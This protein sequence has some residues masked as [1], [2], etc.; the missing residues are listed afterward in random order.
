MKHVSFM[1]IAGA[2]LAMSGD[3]LVAAPS[4]WPQWQGA[5]RDNLSTETGLLKKWPA[6]GPPLAWKAHGIGGGF[7]TVSVADGK[8]F[9]MGDAADACYV[10]ALDLGGNGIWQAKVGPTG[11]GG[12]Y[13]GP[14]CAP[15]V[16]GNTVVA[17]GQFGDL[18]CLDASTGA[19]KWHKNLQKDFHGSMMSGWGYAES[20]L[21]D[22]D[23]VICT[24][25][26]SDGTLLALD[27]GTGKQVWRCT[28]WKDPAAYAS[29]VI[30]EIGGVR[31]YVQLT[32]DSVGGVTASDGKLLWR[33]DRKGKTA[34]IP[35]PIV[36]GDEIFVTSGYQVGCNLF[37]IAADNG[38]FS[39]T[40]V[41]A[42][43]SMQNHHGGV[44]LVGD[45]L[46]GSSD[47]GILTCMDFQTGK[48]K[49]KDRSVGKGSLTYADGHLYLRAEGSG[50]V[51]LVE[52]T[53]DGYHEISILHQP[54]RSDAKAWPHPVI[55]DGKLYLRD[56]DLLLCYD[57]K[58]H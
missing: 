45:G 8:I 26:G 5:R 28:Q 58:A 24:P 43:K 33:A 1:L 55:A 17:L 9:T 22:Q 15:T 50:D 31:Q 36:K 51:A 18:V 6:D 2:L 46:Y 44:V 25:G 41:Y 11:G 21:I 39:T 34:V 13:P 16:S 20:P 14:R 3:K 52:A 29:P 49:W 37:K 56:Q 35:T 32:G 12:G 19:V 42:N 30:A 4:P 48:V 57:I 47:P 40:E 7:S 27:L 38:K 54:D 23:H 53:P 10:F